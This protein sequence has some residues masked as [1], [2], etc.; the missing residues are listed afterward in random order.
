[1]ARNSTS[2][3]GRSKLG[4]GVKE[5]LLSVVESIGIPNQEA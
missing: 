3:L 4:K 2:G 1:M 5:R